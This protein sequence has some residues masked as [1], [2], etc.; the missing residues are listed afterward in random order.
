MPSRTMHDRYLAEALRQ[1]D[2]RALFITGAGISVASG[3]PTFRGPDPDA[4][5]ANDVMTMATLEY[6]RREP[7]KQWSWYLRRF[8]ACR[9]A[10]P[11]AAHI[12]LSDIEYQLT[13]AGGQFQLI[14]QNID[15]L[16]AA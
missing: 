8:D 10:K 9:L 15:G 11:N 1:P 5:W 2:S 3:I 4:L 13:S 7:V 12:A 14:T 16:H 6:F